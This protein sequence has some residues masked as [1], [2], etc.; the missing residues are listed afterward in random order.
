MGEVLAL[1]PIM[2]CTM[3]FLFL[4]SLYAKQSGSICEE[5]KAGLDNRKLTLVCP[6]VEPVNILSHSQPKMFCDLGQK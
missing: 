2:L 5:L 1:L 6:V 3:R 4:H